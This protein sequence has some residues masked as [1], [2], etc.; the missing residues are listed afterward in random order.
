MLIPPPP[1]ELFT[2]LTN[3]L[4]ERLSKGSPL[5]FRTGKNESMPGEGFEP[6]TSA[7]P[8]YEA[9]RASREVSAPKL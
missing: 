4:V 8:R 2:L 9:R 3:P 1:V 6:S 5:N 7:C